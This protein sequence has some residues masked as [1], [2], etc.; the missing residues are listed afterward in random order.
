MIMDKHD[1]R[2]R[3]VER[4]AENIARTDKRRCQRSRRDYLVPV[5]PM[6]VIEREQDEV[7]FIRAELRKMG[8][9]TRTTS[10][11]PAAQSLTSETSR[12]TL[13]VFT[14]YRIH[15]SLKE[16]YGKVSNA[17]QGKKEGR[18]AVCG[19][20]PNEWYQPVSH[21]KR[22]LRVPRQVLAQK[23]FF[24]NEPPYEHRYYKHKAQ[25]PPP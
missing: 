2:S 25:N 10:S 20:L 19:Q 24:I 4:R 6:L 18:V 16:I 8:F 12:P 13:N 22:V 15:S 23:F 17:K 3:Q 11:D 1:R 9:A 5:D 7:F 14:V 21:F